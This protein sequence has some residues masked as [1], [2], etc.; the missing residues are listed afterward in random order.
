MAEMSV[1]AN[2][3]QAVDVGRCNLDVI[4][5]WVARRLT[6]LLGIDDD[7]VIELV[8]SMLEDGGD[9][10]GSS[11][12]LRGKLDPRYM[13]WS[14]HG[15]LGDAKAMTFM[16]ELWALLLSAQAAP[17]G[18][19]PSFVDDKKAQLAAARRVDKHEHDSAR[20]HREDVDRQRPVQ[21][22]DDFER[23]MRQ[24]QAPASKRE[25]SRSLG[26]RRDDRRRREYRD[27]RDTRRPSFD[28]RDLRGVNSRGRR[29]SD[30]SYAS[31][32]SHRE[33]SYSRPS[34]E[35]ARYDARSHRREDDSRRGYSDRRRSEHRPARHDRRDRDRSYD[36]RDRDRS[37]DRRDRDRSFDRHDRRDD[38][39]AR[40]DDVRYDRSPPARRSRSRSRRRPLRRSRSR[41]RSRSYS[42]ESDGRSYDS[43]SSVDSR[44]DRGRRRSPSSQRRA[45]P[46]PPARR[47]VSP[48]RTTSAGAAAA[49][50]NGTAPASTVSQKSTSDTAK[51][52]RARIDAIKREQVSRDVRA[53]IDAL[54]RQSGSATTENGSDAAGVDLADTSDVGT[55]VAQDLPA[56]ERQAVEGR[57]A[58]SSRPSTAGTWTAI[59][60]DMPEHDSSS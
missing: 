3:A 40:R 20:R 2:F 59:L 25:R 35:S 43:R 55:S 8:L 28:A 53:R 7:V 49:T 31:S 18:I 23:P 50:S 19:P 51:E 13:Q 9:G 60:R 26:D 39:R 14:L 27:D 47:Q 6:E 57:P 29:G 42:V 21:S 15:F 16:R 48:Q 30:A 45:S 33:H 44:S 56:V 58:A 38:R 5:P 17:G 46:P 41:S 24:R 4:R 34:R 12:R 54:K 32:R 11:S 10:G 36:R 22:V 1:P 37:Y 52:V